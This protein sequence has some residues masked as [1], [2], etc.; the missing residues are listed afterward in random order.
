[1]AFSRYSA[2]IHWLVYGHRTSN[3]E[4]VPCQMPWA[5]NKRET[6]HCYLWNVD[7]CCTWS[8]VTWCCAGISVLFSKFAFVRL[9]ETLRFSGNKIHRSPRDQ[10]LSVKCFGFSFFRPHK[11]VLPQ[12]E[13]WCRPSWIFLLF[14]W[15]WCKWSWRRSCNKDELPFLYEVL[16]GPSLLLFA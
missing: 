16:Y 8:E 7:R 6:V 3:N 2:S 9:G 5:C 14:L 11:S 15:W 13:S 4:T 10:S 12:R 1:M